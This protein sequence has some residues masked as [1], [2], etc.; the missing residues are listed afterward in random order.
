[1][2]NGGGG[3]VNIYPLTVTGVPDER[4]KQAIID[5][6]SPEHRRPLCD[7]V[8]VKDPIVQS[9]QIVAELTLLEGYREDI[10]KTK[11]LDALQDYLAKRTKKLGMDVVPSALMQVLRV[12]G[13]YD[14]AIQQPT[15]MILNATEWANCTKITLNINGV[16]QNG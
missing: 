16:R 1:M 9:Y 6:L 3:K 11:A 7:V 10:V 14:V 4:L 8:I 15:K 5:A 12:E 2:I 13:V